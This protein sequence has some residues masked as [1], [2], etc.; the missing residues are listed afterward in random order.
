MVKYSEAR[1][2]KIDK[3][4]D[5]LVSGVRCNKF[6]YPLYQKTLTHEILYYFFENCKYYYFVAL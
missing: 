5:E 2:Q 3:I 1:Q 4:V 6:H